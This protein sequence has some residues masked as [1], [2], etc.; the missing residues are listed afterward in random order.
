M[1]SGRPKHLG[2][3]LSPPPQILRFAQNDISHTLL[4]RVLKIPP[5]RHVIPK[6][7]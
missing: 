1:E 6:E 4:Q 3:G 2:R 7:S 5:L